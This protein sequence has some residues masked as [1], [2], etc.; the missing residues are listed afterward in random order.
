[1]TYED[2]QKIAELRGIQK[3]ELDEY[4]EKFEESFPDDNPKELLA[5]TLI[6]HYKERDK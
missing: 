3:K 5:E 6:L 4:L 1:M 2:L